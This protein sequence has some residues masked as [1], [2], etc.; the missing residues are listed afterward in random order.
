L[1]IVASKISVFRNKTC[2]IPKVTPEGPL[3]ICNT[4]LQELEATS[5]AGVTYEWTN[6][7]TSTSVSGT[8]LFTP[9]VTGNYQVTATSEGGI[10]ITQSNIINVV[11]S[12]GTAADPL[13]YYDEP[14]CL[15][16]TLSLKLNNNL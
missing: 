4:F 12:P 11:V 9:S 10:C 5:S 13:P 2:L 14:L 6:H 1:S 16:N 3:N 8:H 7:T 15:G